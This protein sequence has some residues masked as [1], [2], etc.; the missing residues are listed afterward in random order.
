MDKRLENL[1]RALY[2]R[3][4][5]VVGAHQ[6]DDSMWLRNMQTFQGLGYSVNIDPKEIPGMEALGMANDARLTD[7]PGA[8]DFVVV[9]VPRRA[10][11]LVLKDA[12]AKGVAGLAVCTA[13]VAETA[14][15]EGRQLQ[16][17]IV[18]L[19][20]ATKNPGGRRVV[21]AMAAVLYQ[22]PVTEQPDVRP[23]GAPAQSVV[24]QARVV[25]VS[26]RPGHHKTVTSAV[27]C[28]DR[29]QTIPQMPMPA[30]G[31]QRR[32]LSRETWRY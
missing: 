19:A 24:V 11:P 6:A 14:E 7:I 13:G 32:W 16:Q 31:N 22:E 17:T 28:H 12:I 29:C 2:P 27:P 30:S 15:E 25:W 3:A 9:A 10:A 21:P 23:V 5:A 1:H 4:V 8:V 20:G 26:T 18:A